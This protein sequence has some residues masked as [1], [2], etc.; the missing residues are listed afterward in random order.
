[1]SH[2]ERPELSTPHIPQYWQALKQRA[3]GAG[4]EAANLPAKSSLY[5]AF[6]YGKNAAYSAEGGRSLVKDVGTEMA[7]IED[8]MLVRPAVWRSLPAV[9]DFLT[10]ELVEEV[11]ADDRRR[12]IDALA[13]IR[14]YWPEAATEFAAHLASVVWIKHR[15]TYSASDPK[16][17]GVIFLNKAYFKAHALVEMAT[18]IIHEAAHHTL[19]VETAIDPMIPKNFAKSLFSP[20][21]QAERPA[22]GV[23]HGLYSMIRMLLWAR[24]LTT[25]EPGR[26]DFMSESERM[27]G[28]FR[29]GLRP[30]IEEL[31]GVGLSPGGQALIEAMD[32]VERQLYG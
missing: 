18:D 30:A 13:M 19:F 6:T 5:P 3:L 26:A 4:A 23:L 9:Q 22:I 24:R 29:D 15:E 14:K 16:L 10:Y 25:A 20:I 27:D 21:R 32:R 12:L 7:A 17:Y 11:D 8:G 1:M 31:K 28:L 2:L